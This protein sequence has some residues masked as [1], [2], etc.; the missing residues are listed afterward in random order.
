MERKVDASTCTTYVPEIEY[1][2]RLPIMPGPKS[3]LLT[4]DENAKRCRTCALGKTVTTDFI[5]QGERTERA[6]DKLRDEIRSLRKQIQ[7]IDIF[8]L[9]EVYTV[10]EISGP[11]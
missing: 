6:M 4:M 9:Q 11:V 3:V 2:I 7:V 8:P 5:H 10:C 1:P